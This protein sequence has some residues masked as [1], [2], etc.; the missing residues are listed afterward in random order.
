[1]KLLK[2]FAGAACL[3]ISLPATAQTGATPEAAQKFI[4]IV[5]KQGATYA[6]VSDV[7]ISKVMDQGWNCSGNSVCYFTL[8]RS[9]LAY[10]T[11]AP[12]KCTTSISV[13]ISETSWRGDHAMM[14][15][16]ESPQT[17]IVW[18]TISGVSLGAGSTSI[19]L[20][21]SGRIRSLTFATPDLAVRV[22]NAFQTLI[23]ACDPTAGTGF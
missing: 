7:Q 23:K 16:K 6:E 2:M 8:S 10:W 3:A 13:S 11:S 14:Y 15:V 5:L 19:S 1:M 18:S 20:A 4:E 17:S 12:N 22:K 21:G 9:G